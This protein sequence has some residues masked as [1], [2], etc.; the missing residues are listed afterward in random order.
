MSIFLL[1]DDQSGGTKIMSDKSLSISHIKPP[2]GV[3]CV[4]F[5]DDNA[6]VLTYGKTDDLVAVSPPQPMVA[7]FCFPHLPH[8]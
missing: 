4:C 2:K 8:Q 5:K 6:V 1:S 3:Q 7:G